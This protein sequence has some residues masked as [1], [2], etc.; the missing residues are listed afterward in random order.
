MERA[1]LRLAV[2]AT[3][4]LG[5]VSRSGLTVVGW[6][7]NI[8]LIPPFGLT[9]SAGATLIS[10]A[11]LQALLQLKA[12]RVAP[13]A[14]PGR[15]SRLQ[16]AAAAALALTSAAVPATGVAL[17]PRIAVVLLTMAW[18]FRLLLRA[19]RRAVA[20][21]PELAAAGSPSAGADER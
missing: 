12:R 16:L 10:Y 2:F 21:R 20:V 7:L 13:T 11:F 18:F 15:G 6:V 1:R 3:T 9:G 19:N 4:V 8:V 17:W 14:A 5:K